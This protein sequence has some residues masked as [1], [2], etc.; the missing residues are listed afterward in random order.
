M[1]LD[2]FKLDGKVALVTGAG[3]GLGQAIAVALAEAGADLAILGRRADALSDTEKCIGATGR[4]T[5]AISADVS[6][7]DNVT[8]AV[9][10]AES[11]LGPIDILVNAAGIANAD[12]TLDLKEEDWRN[13]IDINL[14]GTFFA[15]QAA[16]GGDTELAGV[17]AGAGRD[18]H[19]GAG[20]SRGEAGGGQIAVQ[21][22]EVREADPA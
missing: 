17:R 18:V 11:A 16:G 5:H 3:S 19:E 1:I 4:K 8:R 9:R 13:V 7:K 12:D 15:C 14:T 6:K 21:I 10:E 20:A 2:R 22:G